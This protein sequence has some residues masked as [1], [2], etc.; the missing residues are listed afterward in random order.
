[1]GDGDMGDVHQRGYGGRSSIYKLTAVLK[2]DR[3]GYADNIL[4]KQKDMI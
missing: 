3:W 1:M 2:D 4:L